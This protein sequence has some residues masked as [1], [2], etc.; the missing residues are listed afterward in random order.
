MLQLASRRG[1]RARVFSTLAI[2]TALIFLAAPAFA[3]NLVVNPNF[4]TTLVPWTPFLSSAPD[5]AGAGS[6]NWVPTPDVNGN[7][8]SGSA[9]ITIAAAPAAANAASGID[10]CVPFASTTVSSVN[11]GVS[12]LVPA[13]N[14][15]DGGANATIEIR[16]FS[17]GACTN[18]ISGAGGSQGQDIVPGIPNNATWYTII[19]PN[20]QPA[21]PVTAASVQLR[22]YLRKTGASANAYNVNF[23]KVFVFLNGS[24]PVRLQQFDVE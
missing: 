19:D 22:A 2:M 16:L 17:D 1:S 23:D 13:T 9:A 3:Q 8:G 18:F 4:N 7:A 10:E 11:Y 15:P 24:T 6:A 12:F 5:P 14:L 20:F 21:A